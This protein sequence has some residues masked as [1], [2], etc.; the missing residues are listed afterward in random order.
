MPA[1]KI[2]TL[3]VENVGKSVLIK[4][5]ITGTFIDKV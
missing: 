1:I 3:G 4:K 5:F 2:I